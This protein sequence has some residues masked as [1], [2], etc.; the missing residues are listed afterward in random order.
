MAIVEGVRIAALSR[1]V[2]TDKFYQGVVEVTAGQS[3]KIE[4]SPGGDEL[5][6]IT[7]PAGMTYTVSVRVEYTINGS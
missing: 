2:K 3:F 1:P 4:T 7:V 6:D 5:L